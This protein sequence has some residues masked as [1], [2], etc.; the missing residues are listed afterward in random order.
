[1]NL[2]G[3]SLSLEEREDRFVSLE[4]I[5][6][7]FRDSKETEKATRALRKCP[8]CRAPY[9]KIDGCE[10]MK[11]GRCKKLFNDPRTRDELGHLRCCSKL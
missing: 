1:V 5:K 3:R 10:H 4:M 9:M 11:C 6:T 8:K 7:N 2:M